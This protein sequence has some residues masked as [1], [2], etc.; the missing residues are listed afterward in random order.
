MAQPI[1]RAHAVARRAAQ[2]ERSRGGAEQDNSTHTHTHTLTHTRHPTRANKQPVDWAVLNHAK[3][4]KIAEFSMLKIGTAQS[5]HRFKELQSSRKRVLKWSGFY[6]Y[7]C[8]KDNLALYFFAVPDRRR[9]AGVQKVMDGEMCLSS[10]VRVIQKHQ[11]PAVIR[12][13]DSWDEP[14]KESAKRALPLLCNKRSAC[15][16]WLEAGCLQCAV[17]RH[18]LYSLTGFSY[19]E[20]S[21][22]AR[23]TA[24]QIL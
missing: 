6:F 20:R 11:P 10:C 17:S 15:V 18:V 7:L 4:Q 5:T 13:G 3:R 8:K 23:Q 19:A 24:N 16:M 9:V 21:V 22:Q 14:K 1:V 12:R 2:R